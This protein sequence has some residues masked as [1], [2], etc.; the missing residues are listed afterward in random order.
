MTQPLVFI[1]GRQRSFWAF[2]HGKT[3]RESN[4]RRLLLRHALQLALYV[5]VLMS[6]SSVR[7][8]RERESSL[9]SR[10]WSTEPS[11]SEK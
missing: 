7:I 6:S 4:E 9:T 2:F 3:L 10:R 8:Q 11:G 1:Y 5:C